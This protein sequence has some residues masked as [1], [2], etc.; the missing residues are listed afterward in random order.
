MKTTYAKPF[1]TSYHQNGAALVISLVLLVVM[2][3][4]GV[5]SMSTSL[6][7]EKMAANAQSSNITFQAA[8][9]AIGALVTEIIVNRNFT[10]LENA[11]ADEGV[12]QDRVVIDVDDPN[13]NAG[14]QITYLGE[15]FISGE[16]GSS[17]DADEDSTKIEATRYDITATGVMESNNAQTVIRQGFIYN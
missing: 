9:S 16:A 6:M 4:I 5:A 14:F 12:Q 10:Q 13:V 15:V 7:Q 11:V 3:L 17:T 2:T 1:S 8:E